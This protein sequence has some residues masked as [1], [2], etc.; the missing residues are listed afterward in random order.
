MILAKGAFKIA[1][2]CR[3][4]KGTR[5]GINMK[6]RLFLDG[7]DMRG[8]G[9]F[10]NMCVKQ[11]VLILTYGTAAKFTVIQTAIVRTERTL[12][13]VVFELYVKISLSHKKE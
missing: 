1:A 9:A 5:T 3:N 7:I 8:N 2:N 10:V 13:S 12:Y 11:T 4:G 6:E